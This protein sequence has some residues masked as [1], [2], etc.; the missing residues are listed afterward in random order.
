MKDVSPLCKKLQGKT[1]PYF[2]KKLQ[3]KT[4]PY[5]AKKFKKSV[6]LFQLCGIIFSVKKLDKIIMVQEKL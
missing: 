1:C 3:G 4:C 2:A 6:L 5:F